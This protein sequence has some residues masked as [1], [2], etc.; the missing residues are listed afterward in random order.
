MYVFMYKIHG[1]QQYYVYL[2]NN[3]KFELRAEKFQN[4]KLIH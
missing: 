2:C 1:R 3:N 4:N